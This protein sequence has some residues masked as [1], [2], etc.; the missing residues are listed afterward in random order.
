MSKEKKLKA[1]RDNMLVTVLLI[2]GTLT[3]FLPL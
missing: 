2:I 1:G 3:V